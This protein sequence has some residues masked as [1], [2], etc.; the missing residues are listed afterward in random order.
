MPK[1]FSIL[2]KSISDESSSNWIKSTPDIHSYNDNATKQFRILS[3]GCWYPLPPTVSL[4]TPWTEELVHFE[5]HLPVCTLD[6][7]FGFHSQ[8]S[9][10]FVKDQ[11]IFRVTFL[12]HFVFE[13]FLYLARV[14]CHP[15]GVQSDF[16]YV[17]R[18]VEQRLCLLFF[19]SI[20]DVIQR[21]RLMISLSLRVRSPSKYSNESRRSGLVHAKLTYCF[22]GLLW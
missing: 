14:G 9:S 12:R 10:A 19:V 3:F 13:E 17:L 15:D 2:N 4:W 18:K 1:L 20:G 21:S 11:L 6:V 16:L 5:M 8:L 22:G 7:S